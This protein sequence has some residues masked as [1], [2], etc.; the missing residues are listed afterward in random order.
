[1]ISLA[2]TDPCKLSLHLCHRLISCRGRLVSQMIFESQGHQ[3]QCVPQVGKRN[4]KCLLIKFTRF[5]FHVLPRV[6][7][8]FPSLGPHP[9]LGL[10]L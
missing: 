2:H 8:M 9:L 7:R 4:R 10:L 6:F 5:G 1:M 3:H